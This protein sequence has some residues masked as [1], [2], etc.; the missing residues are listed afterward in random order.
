MHQSSEWEVGE[1]VL[2]K[3]GE[4]IC[5]RRQEARMLWSTPFMPFPASHLGS[6][7]L[8]HPRWMIELKGRWAPGQACIRGHGDFIPYTLAV[9]PQVNLEAGRRLRGALFQSFIISSSTAAGGTKW[10]VYWI[11]LCNRWF[12][13]QSFSNCSDVSAL[14]PHCPSDATPWG[15]A[16]IWIPVYKVSPPTPHPR[17]HLSIERESP[18]TTKHPRAP[19]NGCTWIQEDCS[20]G[21]VLPQSNLLPEV[22]SIC[23]TW[24]SLKT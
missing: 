16:L 20:L 8:L 13:F 3:T 15:W 6:T 22:D 1:E 2:E 14:D 24:R 9:L 11:W 5:Q 10:R 7:S 23:S 17:L 12:C 18:N 19:N 21:Q 4:L